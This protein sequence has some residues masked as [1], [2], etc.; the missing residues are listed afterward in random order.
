MANEM[1]KV[2]LGYISF[3]GNILCRAY[4]EANPYHDPIVA[5]AAWMDSGLEMSLHQAID[6]DVPMISYNDVPYLLREYRAQLN[7][8]KEMVRDIN[9]DRWQAYKAAARS[10]SLY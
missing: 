10:K 3:D 4:M 2:D 9:D 6:E 7:M 5:V 1:K 8:V